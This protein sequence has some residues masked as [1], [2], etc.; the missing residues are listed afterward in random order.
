MPIIRDKVATR[1]RIEQVRDHAARQMREFTG[2]RDDAHL[3]III[4]NASREAIRLQQV[5]VGTPHPLTAGAWIAPP[6]DWTQEEM[7]RVAELAAADAHI[8]AI[9]DASN[10]LEAMHPDPGIPDDFRDL[11]YWPNP[12]AR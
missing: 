7:L 4:A 2:A 11:K 3:S 9:R 10:A 1:P 6:R 8:E 12:P 5:R